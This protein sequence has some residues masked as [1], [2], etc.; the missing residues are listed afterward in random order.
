MLSLLPAEAPARPRAARVPRYRAESAP[1][2]PTTRTRLAGAADVYAA[3]ADIKAADREHFVA[4]HLDVRH[5]VIE[6]RIVSIGS[7][8]GVEVHPR[9]VFKAAI[10]ASAAAIIIVHNHPSGD[11]YPS[12]QDIELTQRLRDVG[13]MV[14]IPVVDHVI[15]SSGGYTSLAE[16]NWR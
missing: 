8:T 6:R 2:P 16:R 12:R 11:T 3:C 1:P 14:G 5:K 7:L 9:E 15:V 13:E 4:F 10:V